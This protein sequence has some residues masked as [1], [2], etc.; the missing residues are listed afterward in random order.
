MTRTKRQKWELDES[1][2]LTRNEVKRLRRIC[3]R[4]SKVHKVGVRDFLIIDLGLYCGL[5]VQEIADLKVG[6]ILISDERS[7]LI[8][9]NG[10]GG[11]RR[12]VR[13]NGEF[14]KHFKDYL[15]WKV[16]NKE[17]VKEEDPLIIS[18]NTGGHLS[19]RAV[20][21]AFERCSRLAGIDGH[22]SHHLRHTFACHFY[23]ASG[24]NL[25]AV[26]KQLGH[27]NVKTTQIYADVFN[28]DVELALEK[29]YMN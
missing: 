8:V 18:S 7:S 9:R 2:F 16:A 20:Q 6:D 5:R 26:Q 12:V 27:S 10:K 13:F 17:W 11:K 19:K 15:N 1:K 29:L 14:K 3:R 24:Y 28:E 25:R 21:R 23:K 22:S 4:R